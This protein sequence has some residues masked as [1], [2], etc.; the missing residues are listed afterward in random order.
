MLCDLGAGLRVV[1]REPHAR[2]DIGD[3][4]RAELGVV[5]K[6]GVVNGSVQLSEQLR[7]ARADLI[8]CGAH[9]RDLA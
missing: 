4:R 3:E 6:T 9:R 1:L 5:A 7:D 8:A 2:L